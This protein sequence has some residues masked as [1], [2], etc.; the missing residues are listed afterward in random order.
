MEYKIFYIQNGELHI[1]I[2]GSLHNAKHFITEMRIKDYYI[3]QDGTIM[4]EEIIK[5]A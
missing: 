4:S 1:N 3:V 2:E 5:K